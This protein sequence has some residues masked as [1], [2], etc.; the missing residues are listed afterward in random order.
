M[1]RCSAATPRRGHLVEHV[2]RGARPPSAR[3]VHPIR[4]TSTPDL[5]KRVRRV[6]EN[7][8]RVGSASLAWKNQTL[9]S[10]QT[11]KFSKIGFAFFHKGSL[12]LLRFFGE[13]I[14][15]SRIARELLQAR[16]S[17]RIG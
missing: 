13:V 10:G 9:Y 12:A 8:P 14:Q 11:R 17:V 1:Y 6:P 5:E 7:A 3:R 16:E 15:Q 4:E 2:A